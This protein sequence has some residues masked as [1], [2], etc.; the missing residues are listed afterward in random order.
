METVR[1]SAL[2]YSKCV[3][4]LPLTSYK[5]LLSY[6]YKQKQKPLQQRRDAIKPHTKCPRQRLRSRRFQDLKPGERLRGARC[7]CTTFVCRASCL[8][9]R[10]ILREGESKG[11]SV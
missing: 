5:E 2:L 7:S 1:Y 3:M 4:V 11:F 8:Q 9:V 10:K 6:V